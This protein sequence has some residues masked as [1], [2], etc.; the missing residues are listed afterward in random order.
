[1]GNGGG[2][3]GGY[4]TTCVT[5]KSPTGER[6]LGEIAP[7]VLHQTG[8]NGNG[9]ASGLAWGEEVAAMVQEMLQRYSR[10]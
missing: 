10:E 9:A 2:L 8:C 3:N 7:G 6:L 1:M 5:A 4:V